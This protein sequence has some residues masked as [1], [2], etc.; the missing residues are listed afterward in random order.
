MNGFRLTPVMGCDSGWTFIDPKITIPSW[1][2]MIFFD[3]VIFILT[4]VRALRVCKCL[5]F[6]FHTSYDTVSYSYFLVQSG[7][8]RLL[9]ILVRDGFV[10]YAVMLCTPLSLLFH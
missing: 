1:S 10:Y 4:I 7:T 3:T 2:A 9:T 6:L 5:F 8:T